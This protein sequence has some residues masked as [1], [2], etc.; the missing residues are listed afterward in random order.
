MQQI[1]GLV[2]RLLLP[3]SHR[4]HLACYLASSSPRCVQPGPSN[5]WQQR[6]YAS[7]TTVPSAGPL[8]KELKGAAKLS[9][10]SAKRNSLTVV[11]PEELEEW[12]LT[13]G[14]E[15]HAQLN[16]P[17][18]L[19]SGMVKQGDL[20]N[21]ADHTQLHRQSR[22]ITQTG[23]SPLSICPSQVVSLFSRRGHSYQP[24]VQL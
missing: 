11:T 7:H 20:Q 6:Q 18:K 24:C 14:I 1:C 4:P 12:E 8:R 22:L 10:A 13:V 21:E 19:F 16:T 15:I 17:T 3:T 2:R 9:K 23:M 5:A